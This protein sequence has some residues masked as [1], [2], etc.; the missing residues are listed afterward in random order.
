MKPN[1][2]TFMSLG[3]VPGH[4]QCDNKPDYIATERK[5]DKDG[6]KGS[7]SMCAK[8]AVVFQEQKGTKYADLVSI[9]EVANELG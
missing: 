5:P 7:M 3:G 6:R 4:I 8:C 2:H 1:G 9:E